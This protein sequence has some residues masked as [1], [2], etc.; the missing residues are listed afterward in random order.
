[1][2]AVV[3][4][5]TP[6]GAS[7]PQVEDGGSRALA[8]AVLVLGGVWTAVS[9]LAEVPYARVALDYAAEEDPDDATLAIGALLGFGSIVLILPLW[10]V[11][12]LWL[13]AERRRFAGRRRFKHGTPGTFFSWVVPIANFVWPFWIVR[14]VHEAAVEPSRRES[15]GLWWALW[16]LALITGRVASSLFDAQDYGDPA[17][18]IIATSAVFVVLLVA[19][20]ATWVKVV[21]S[22]STGNGA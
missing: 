3:H 10:I 13:R 20:Y 4:L 12:C 7:A 1:M 19:A 16:V 6:S 21:R 14:E 5:P 2:S 11:T 15:L 9:V 17:G 18:A 8:I 22:T